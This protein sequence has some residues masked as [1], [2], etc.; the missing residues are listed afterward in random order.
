MSGLKSYRAKSTVSYLFVDR[1]PVVSVLRLQN[2]ASPMLLLSY[3]SKYL[4]LISLF[5][6]NF[7]QLSLCSWLQYFTEITHTHN[8]Q[9][10]RQ[11]SDS[12]ATT[13]KVALQLPHHL[14]LLLLLHY[15]ELLKTGL[16]NAP[17]CELPSKQRRMVAKL[18]PIPGIETNR[19][20]CFDSVKRESQQ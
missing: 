5:A 17:V 20:L 2:V 4:L 3:C 10:S 19:E 16:W 15:S 11:C 1:W 9:V 8:G 6:S 7:Y 12:F 18:V 14:Y 13:A